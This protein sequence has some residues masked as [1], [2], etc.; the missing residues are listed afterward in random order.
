MDL[1]AWREENLAKRQIENDKTMKIFLDRVVW[2]ETR[3]KTF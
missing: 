2:R 1:S 3:E